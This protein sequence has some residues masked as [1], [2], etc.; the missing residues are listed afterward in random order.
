MLRSTVAIASLGATCARIFE[1]TIANSSAPFIAR[2]AFGVDKSGGSVGSASLS[3][4][5]SGAQIYFI[6][7][8]AQ[9]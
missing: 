9:S 2:F 3:F 5:P 6:Y 1:G 4:T 7:N 8:A